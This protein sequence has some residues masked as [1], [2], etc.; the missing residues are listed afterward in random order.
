MSILL[1]EIGNS[2]VKIAMGDASV[3]AD[4]F[5]VT[6]REEFFRQS[7]A[8]GFWQ[9]P[10][11]ALAASHP[12][13]ITLL[14]GQIAAAGGELLVLDANAPLP[15]AVHYTSGAPGAD[16]LA[17]AI[18]LRHR[19]D[20]GRNGI[21]GSR[22]AICVDFGTATHIEVVDAAGDFLGGAILPGPQLGLDALHRASRGRLPQ[23]TMEMLERDGPAIGNSTLGAISR[24]VLIGH[25]GAIDRLIDEATAQLRTEPLL[26]ATGRTAALHLGMLRHECEYV[27][28]L[29]L[30]GLALWARWLDSR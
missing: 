24:G 5:N 17:N 10:R 20:H 2:S 3:A 13:D 27:P 21:L 25:A 14:Q 23:L 7:T 15:M 19:A 6:S 4:E 18:A 16:R 11:V 30:E 9:Q 26:V 8:P 1:V 22:P 12:E 28:Q 29:T